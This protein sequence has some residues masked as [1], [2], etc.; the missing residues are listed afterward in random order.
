MYA[1]WT[2]HDFEGPDGHGAARV[3]AH[4]CSS[5][6]QYLGPGTILL[7]CLEGASCFILRETFENVAEG[8]KELEWLHHIGWDKWLQEW[9]LKHGKSA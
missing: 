5:E 8:R 9:K 7:G 6:L 2:E 4:P 3:D 1:L